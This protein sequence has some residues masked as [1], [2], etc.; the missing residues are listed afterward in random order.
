MIRRR[1]L[2]CAISIVIIIALFCV[3]PIKAAVYADKVLELSPIAY[4]QLNE[5]S[6]TTIEDSSGNGYDGTYYGVTLNQIDGAG[7]TMGRAGLWDGLNDWADV[8]SAGLASVYNSDK[9]TVILWFKAYDSAVWSGTAYKFIVSLR[10]ETGGS[11]VSAQL[12]KNNAENQLL[13]TYANGNTFPTSA[14]SSTDWTFA[15][16]VRDTSS[17]NEKWYLNNTE[18]NSQAASAWTKTITRASIGALNQAHAEYYFYGYIQHVAI[19]D[20]ALSSDQI[21]YLANSSPPPTP[22]PTATVSTPTPRSPHLITTLSNGN[23]FELEYRVTAGDIA[24]VIPALMLIGLL[25]FIIILRM[26][27]Q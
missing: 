14:F 3:T 18:I 16:I 9:Y 11:T 8:F 17:N 27:K 2:L 26:T 1:L 20:T 25:A 23:E 10:T 13:L 15:A 6:G 19:F 4:W 5:V 7:S 12:L 22:T 24:Q 21:A